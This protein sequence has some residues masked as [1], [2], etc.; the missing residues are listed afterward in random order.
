MFFH[1]HE[2]LNLLCHFI[3][4]II[5]SEHAHQQCYSTHKISILISFLC[6]CLVDF[7]FFSSQSNFHVN[8][9]VY[10]LVLMCQNSFILLQ[11]PHRVFPSFLCCARFPH[12]C[13]SR[14]VV[15]LQ[16]RGYHFPC[17]THVKHNQRKLSDLKMRLQHVPSVLARSLHIRTVQSWSRIGAIVEV[18]GLVS[19]FGDFLFHTFWAKEKI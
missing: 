13:P 6:L 19:F 3:A 2:I 14:V 15:W 16:A 8:S 18:A 10:F 9:F 12:M 17:C 5:L 4:S 7:H 1:A 11:P